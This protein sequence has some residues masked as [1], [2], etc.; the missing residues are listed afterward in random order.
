MKILGAEKGRATLLMNTEEYE[1]KLANML[2]DTNTYMKLDKDPTP[3]Y[4]I[5]SRLEQEGNIR[6]EDKIFVPSR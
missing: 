5:M 4:K 3:K 6:P 2:N 1:E